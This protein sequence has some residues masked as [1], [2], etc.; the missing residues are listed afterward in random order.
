MRTIS[1]VA[2]ALLVAS[3]AHAEEKRKPT[4]CKSGTDER[5]LDIQSREGGGCKVVY[6]NA[7]GSRTVGEAEHQLDFCNQLVEKMIKRFEASGYK[8]N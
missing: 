3:F 4:V 6:S 7:A 8:C 1:L 5:T 2:L